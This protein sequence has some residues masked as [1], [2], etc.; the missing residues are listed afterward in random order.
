MAQKEM[1][2]IFSRMGVTDNMFWL[3]AVEKAVKINGMTYSG[4]C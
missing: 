1:I 3:G 2:H 4:N